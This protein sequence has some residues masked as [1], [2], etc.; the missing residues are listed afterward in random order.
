M[1]DEFNT[2][3]VNPKPEKPEEP[4]DEEKKEPKKPDFE[5]EDWG[6]E[7][8]APV[9][10]FFQSDDDATRISPR[11]M[12]IESEP[13][14]EANEINSIPDDAQAAETQAFNQLKPGEFEKIEALPPQDRMPDEDKPAEPIFHTPEPA[15]PIEPE[16]IDTPQPK[17]PPQGATPVSGEPPK[18]RRTWLI[19][20]IVL[21]VLCLC[22]FI[23]AIV[24]VLAGLIPF[25][26]MQWDT[27]SMIRAI[28]PA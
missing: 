20:L 15:T 3:P 19:V 18:T 1:S 23:T 17:T 5:V 12:Q 24:L 28:L 10:D 13:L 22:C 2:I 16:V 27:Q 6:A 25:N 7:P 4:A 11:P 8:P 26:S 21:L 9:P 14:K